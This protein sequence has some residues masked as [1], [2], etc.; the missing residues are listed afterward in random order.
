MAVTSGYDPYEFFLQPPQPLD[1]VPDLREAVRCNAV[2]IP[3]GVERRLLQCYQFA[4]SVEVEAELSGVGDEGQPVQ[5]RVP[6]SALPPV[7]AAGVG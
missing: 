5:L 3:V 6:I 4:D 1:A 7:R 2:C